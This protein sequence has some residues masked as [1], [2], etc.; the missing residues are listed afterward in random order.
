M[1]NVKT[2]V[3]PKIITA[4]GIISKSFR[5]HLCNTPKQHEIN[6]LQKTAIQYTAHTLGK[7]LV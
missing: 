7:E 5:K 2:E 6:E 1:W 4:T 3:I